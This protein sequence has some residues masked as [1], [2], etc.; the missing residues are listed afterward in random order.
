MTEISEKC[1]RVLY[2]VANR[3][4]QK[5]N[6]RRREEPQLGSYQ[7]RPFTLLPMNLLPRTCFEKLIFE[8]WAT[9]KD[10]ADAFWGPLWS[11]W[12]FSR[13]MTTTTM[14]RRYIT[15]AARDFTSEIQSSDVYLWCIN[16]WKP[17]CLSFPSNNR[18]LSW[19]HYGEMK[20][21]QT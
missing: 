1:G 11:F 4:E 21:T 15:F 13:Y 19:R 12:S 20:V 10:F 6:C 14:H 2:I 17:L 5:T 7:W 16:I 9:G 18:S 8:L 3:T